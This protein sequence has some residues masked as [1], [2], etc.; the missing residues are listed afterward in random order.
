M[1]EAEDG[2]ETLLEAIRRGLKMFICGIFRMRLKIN[3]GNKTSPV[4]NKC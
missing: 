2:R 3:V 4:K 1:L